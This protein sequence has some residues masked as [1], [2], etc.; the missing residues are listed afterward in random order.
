MARRKSETK[1]PEVVKAY[2]VVRNSCFHAGVEY[3]IGDRLPELPLA[4]LNVHLP[5]LELVEVEEILV[6]DET[7]PEAVPEPEPEAVVEVITQVES[8]G[9]DYH[10]HL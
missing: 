10:V 9:T 8:E 2:R 5:N 6:D 4:Q 1:K 3:K 7:Q